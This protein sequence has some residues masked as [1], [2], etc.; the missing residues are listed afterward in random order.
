MAQTLEEFLVSVKYNIDAPSQQ[1]FFDALKRVSTSVAG[2]AGEITGLGIGI[3]K[4]SETM[5]T[6]GEKLYWTSQRIGDSVTNIQSFTFAMSNLGESS[7]QAM[8]NLERF[9][10]WTRNMGP[11]ATGYL[12][13]LGVTATDALGQMKQLGDYFRSSGG[14]WAQRGTLEY[15]IAMRRAAMMGIDE[16]TMLG[17]SSGRMAEGERQAGMMRRLI[18]G[19]D[20][21]TGPDQF[22]AQSVKV[23]NQF[24]QMGLFFSALEQQFGLGLFGKVEPE[25]RKINVLL[26][27]MLPDIQTFLNHVISYAPAALHFL[28]GAIKAFGTLIHLGGV[29]MDTWDKLP[30]HMREMLVAIVALPKA[31]GLVKSP[32][33]MLIAGFT[34]LMYLIDDYQHFVK[35][36]HTASINWDKIT[37]IFKP[38]TDAAKGM[39]DWIEKFTGVK[40]AVE[41]IG[42][43][44]FAIMLTGLGNL[45]LAAEA[46]ALVFWGPGGIVL[47]AALAGMGLRLT[48][49]LEEQLRNEAK[50]AGYEVIP[51][52]ETQPDM[53][54]DPKTGETLEP[55]VVA[56]RLGHPKG[57]VTPQEMTPHL[58]EQYGPPAPEQYG[59]PE[60]L[61]GPANNWSFGNS[62]LG[63]FLYRGA[64][65]PRRKESSRS[66]G[67]MIA[68]ADDANWGYGGGDIDSDQMFNML[69]DN[70]TLANDRL[71][72]IFD[73][74]T[75]MATNQGVPGSSLP[76]GGGGS[77][78][79]TWGPML[80]PHASAEEQEARLAQIQQRESGGR[81]VFNYMHASNPGYYTASGYY[82][83]IDSTWRHAAKLAGIDTGRYPRAIDAPWEMQHAAALALINEQGER[84]WASSVR[85]M[86]PGTDG[87]ANSASP[88]FAGQF[89]NKR[90]DVH[91]QVSINVVAP[92]PGSAAMQVAEVQERTFEHHVRFARGVLT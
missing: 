67:T 7:D 10:A 15:A 36:P 62:A 35:D 82:Q 19:K 55:D 20:W 8:A 25:L 51:G 61:S 12:R 56:K 53:F 21:Q 85:H 70:F 4:L 65:I 33:F 73:T 39:D 49:M 30:I 14:T 22:A 76:G 42:A 44:G 79:S 83:M 91:N 72:N 32:L 46:L 17:L 29:A 40:N 80:G 26:E 11:A 47:G 6:A 60:S 74:L 63:R 50:A 71:S 59:P 92:N 86:P 81:N 87:A 28:E 88:G 89:L 23:M 16:Q 13:S 31:V 64:L 43:T 68:S 58:S 34:A 90:H 24:R 52:D 54:R 84:P 78:E 18:W 27:Q 1:R 57:Y 66:T 77:D 3:L 45:K 41:W 9:G 69:R 38:F 75:A 5:A 37:Q 2:V 48:G